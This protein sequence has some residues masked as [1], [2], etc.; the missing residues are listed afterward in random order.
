MPERE[1]LRLGPLNPFFPINLGLADIKEPVWNDDGD[2][3]TLVEAKTWE[4]KRVGG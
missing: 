1:S 4:W 2:F 3:A